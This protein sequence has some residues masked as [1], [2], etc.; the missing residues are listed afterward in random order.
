MK[1]F[2][3]CPASAR[4]R[5]GNRVTAVRWARILKSLGHH[6]TIGQD[7]AEQPCDL[8]VALHARRS[9]PSVRT[10]RRLF[11][12]GSLIVALTGT[13]LY[14]DIRTSKHAQQSLQLADR[15][16]V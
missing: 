14:R 11:P 3:A 6:V 8:L 15:L 16:I 5:K 1:I 12:H 7:Y 4:S 10:F 9:Y 13:D 2:M